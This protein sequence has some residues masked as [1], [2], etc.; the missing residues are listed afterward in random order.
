MM[1]NLLILLAFFPLFS[2]SQ[3]SDKFNFQETKEF[4]VPEF[5]NSFYKWKKSTDFEK[6][7]GWKWQARWIE[8]TSKNTTLGNKAPNVNEALKAISSDEKLSS[9]SKRTSLANWSPA[10][11]INRPPNASAYGNHGMGRINCIEFHPTDAN[12]FWV[13]VAQGGVWKTENGG[14]T[15]FP[16]S[17]N[18][19]M[20]R[21]SDIEVNPNNTDEI[22]ICVGDF[23]YIGVG[24]DIDDRKRHTHY[25]LGVYKTTDGGNSW[26]PTGLTYS[27]TQRNNTLMRRTFVNPNNPNEIIAAGVEGIFKSIDG[28]D[29]FTQILDSMIWDFEINPENSNVLIAAGGWV[30]NTNTG[31]AC[32][33][34]STD[35]GDTWKLI[36]APFAPKNEVQRV[37]VTY[38]LSDTN[39]LYAVACDLDR[40][41]NGFYQSTDAGKTWQTKFDKSDSTNILA[42]SDGV[43]EVGGQGAYD[44]CIVVDPTDKNR[45]FVG[46]VNIWGT[47]DG[48]NSFNGVSYW[49][50]YYGPSTHA[51]QH[52]FKVNPLDNKFYLCNDGGLY[53]TNDIQIGDWAQANWG[54]VWPTVWE[55]ISSGMQITSFYRIGLSE[56]NSGD[57]IGGAQDNSTFLKNDNS[58]LN[59][60]G[61]D[62]MEAILHPSD[63]A[64]LF[65]SSQYGRIYSS[66]DTGA[67]YDYYFSYDIWANEEG[68]WTTPYWL[69][70]NDDNH[71]ITG[72]G[73]VYQTKNIGG[74]WS[75]I[76]N[77]NNVPELGQP[78]VSSALKVIPNNPDIIY[79]AKRLYHSLGLS[80]QMYFTKNG[81]VTWSDITSGLPDSLFFTSI[82][83]NHN[84]PDEV[85]VTCA[86]FSNSNKV[87]YS[88][89]AGTTWKN[90]SMNL[91]NLPANT[92]ILD[93]NTNNRNLYLGLNKGVYYT[94][95]TSSNWHLYTDFL[96]NV[97]V[98]ELEIH[99]TDKKLY[100][101]TFGRG[102][103]EANLLDDFGGPPVSNSQVEYENDIEVLPNPNKGVFTVNIL[104]FDKEV[105][106][107]IID[108]MGSL[109][110]KGVFVSA[111]KQFDVKLA[112]GLYYL[113]LNIGKKQV[114]K[115]FM[116]TEGF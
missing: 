42:W 46:G 103:W 74:F 83:A 76:S 90:I 15:Y 22:Y 2:I 96:P 51:D 84:N 59:I 14:Q 94:N 91:P 52:Q 33:L 53:R 16:L 38:A 115:P 4:S 34:K 8:E 73:Q 18:L 58:W 116:I 87:Y 107:Q 70:P 21:I 11:P 104:N 63:E 40:G 67:S 109:V 50:N 92:L 69:N 57:V 98:S 9:K 99:N 37:E 44:L 47:D 19:P 60:I 88:D 36:P 114:V 55:D 85:W 79:V 54:Y 71:L 75:P 113:K 86:G 106:Y 62:G 12:I 105:N 82:E 78:Q 41:F 101:A 27:Q 80:S 10:G 68:A 95:D 100:A 111:Q 48:G 81:G 93:Q 17:D 29:N 110:D 7:K 108:V 28:G 43:D 112:S 25:G 64:I 89:D 31:S 1:K 13:G 102:I 23:A 66:F 32:I 35:F 65:G 3:E 24:L 77:F 56:G 39:F 49:I 5:E 61:G 30:K 20:L 26:Q 6:Q 72:H 45:V 97:I